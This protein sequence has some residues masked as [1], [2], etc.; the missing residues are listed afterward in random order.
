MKNYEELHK[1]TSEINEINTQMEELINQIATLKNNVT[2]LKNDIA[3]LEGEVTK[4]NN[5]L[6]Q[7][8]VIDWGEIKSALSA[9]NQGWI[10]FMTLQNM[11]TEDIGEVSKIYDKFVVEIN[12]N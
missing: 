2:N 5:S 8:F 6:S 4:I 11:P 1:H 3:K 7:G 12:K 10:A 9:F